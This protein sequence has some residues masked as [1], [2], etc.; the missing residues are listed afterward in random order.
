MIRVRSVLIERAWHCS[1]LK[2]GVDLGTGL[3]FSGSG[4]WSSAAG[5]RGWDL[6]IGMVCICV[7]FSQFRHWQR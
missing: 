6:L 5:I 3:V 4:H 1:T 7:V 2:T